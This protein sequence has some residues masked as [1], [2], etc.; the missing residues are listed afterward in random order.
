MAFAQT[1]VGV[2]NPESGSFQLFSQEEAYG[3]NPRGFQTHLMLDSHC[4]VWLIQTTQVS[5]FDPSS[6][7]ERFVPVFEVGEGSRSS[8]IHAW[9]SPDDEVFAGRGNEL[10]KLVVDGRTSAQPEISVVHRADAMITG[11]GALPDKRLFLTTRDG[12]EF[13]DPE[14]GTA[15][16]AAPRADLEFSL[17]SPT[18]NGAH[19]L[20]AEGGLWLSVDREGLVYL[21]PSHAAFSRLPAARQETVAT[22]AEQIRSIGPSMQANTF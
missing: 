21:A 2:Y 1:G 22:V 5:M 19:L 7:S 6:G 18:L 12:L 17:P 14:T 8:I 3:L 11:I 10:I 16:K 20:D 4:R 13:L 15:S 9:I